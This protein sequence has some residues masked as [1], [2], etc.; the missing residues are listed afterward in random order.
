MG[1]GRETWG[2]AVQCVE[3]FSHTEGKVLEISCTALWLQLTILFYSLSSFLRGWI[4]HYVFFT[5]I[6]FKGLSGLLFLLLSTLTVCYILCYIAQCLSWQTITTTNY[7]SKQPRAMY[8]NDFAL[9]NKIT[10]W[11]HQE[12]LRDKLTNLS[13]H[14]RETWELE[15][16][17]DL[18]EVL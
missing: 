13:F 10:K 17:K 15:L 1:E 16:A 6:F 11:Q 9:R 5:T 4:S 18:N 14:K 12:K 7:P 2:V 8:C 3:S